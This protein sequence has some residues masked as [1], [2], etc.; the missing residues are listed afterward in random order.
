[1]DAAVFLSA[2]PGELCYLDPPYAVHQYGS[3]YF[4]L[5]SI[6]LWDRQPVNDER[7]GDGRLLRKAGIRPDWT[8]TRSAFCYRDTAPA[9]MREAV[10]AA[11][12]RWL[13]V[14][15]SNEGLI[16]LE[17]LC[18]LLAE[19]GDLTV[20]SREYAKY[21]GGKQSLHRATR[22]RELVLVVHRG[23]IARRPA[24]AGDALMNVRLERLLALSYS[25]ARIR[26]SFSVR[27]NSI[28]VDVG[29]ETGSA[30]RGSSEALLLMRHL[31]RFA[32][33]AA[34]P[35]FESRLA[36]ES[37][38]ETLAGCVVNDI[39]EEI[40]VLVSVASGLG[41]AREK[42]AIFRESLR[43]LN[44]LAHRKYQAEFADA[45]GTLRS[46]A[47][48]LGAGSSFRSSLAAIEERAKRRIEAAAGQGPQHE[49][50]I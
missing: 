27:G 29:Q 36:A 24:G 42:T 1:M 5:N 2:R 21:P 11:D 14:S 16:G 47:P 31:W 34:L 10:R 30:A 39:R 19:T 28:V 37:F 4:M 41:E 43:L 49:K 12:C 32:P 23:S 44:K 33:E 8:R 17:Q 6:A 38:L 25:P 26:R 13:A 3:N 40:D 9:A 20:R 7:G 35:E 46:A 18:D 22:N 45:L 15:Y 50:R 48:Y